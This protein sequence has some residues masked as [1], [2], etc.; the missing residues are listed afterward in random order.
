MGKFLS[1]VDSE[2]SETPMLDILKGKKKKK[3][4]KVKK[5]E[6]SE[7]TTYENLQPEAAELLLKKKKRKHEENWEITN[8]SMDSQDDDEAENQIMERAV[9]EKTKKEKKPR[10]ENEVQEENAGFIKPE[11]CKEKMKQSEVSLPQTP[12]TTHVTT[13]KKRPLDKESTSKKKKRR[14]LDL[15][16]EEMNIGPDEDAGK[17]EI[18]ESPSWM[19]D[20]E[21]QLLNNMKAQLPRK[22]KMSYRTR[23]KDFNWENAAFGNFTAGDCKSHFKKILTGI[24]SVKTLTI[25]LDEVTENLPKLNFNKR[26]IL[27]P[28][29]RFMRET[30]DSHK[31]QFTNGDCSFVNLS[32]A[33][34]NLPE[35]EKDLYRKPYKK[36]LAEERARLLSKSSRRIKMGEQ[37]PV[38]LPRSPLQIWIAEE[39]KQPNKEAVTCKEWKQKFQNLEKEE[40]LKHII[41]SLKEF[42]EYKKS[43]DEYK[44]KNPDFKFPIIHSPIKSDIQLFLEYRGMPMPPPTRPSMILYHELRKAGELDQISGSEKLMVAM[45]RYKNL[46]SSRKL[47]YKSIL[48]KKMEEYRMQMHA[49]EENQDELTLFMRARLLGDKIKKTAPSASTHHKLLK[50]SETFENVIKC[51]M[52]IPKFLDGPCKPPKSPF[53]LFFMRIKHLAQDQY[54]SQSQIKNACLKE[55]KNLSKDEK[56]RYT[57][58]CEELKEKYAEQILQYVENMNKNLRRL[59]LGVHRKTLFTFFQRDIFEEVYPNKK[60]PVYLLHPRKRKRSEDNFSGEL[61]DD[62]FTADSLSGKNNN[63]NVEFKKKKNENKSD[64]LQSKDKLSSDGYVKSKAVKGTS[65]SD[66]AKSEKGKETSAPTFSLFENKVNYLGTK[67]ILDSFSSD[68]DQRIQENIKT[69][70]EE[71]TKTDSDSE[72]DIEPSQSP[73][74]GSAEASLTT[75]NKLESDDSSSSDGYSDT[76]VMPAWK[77]TKSIRKKV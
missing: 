51:E 11:E 74:K 12:V 30:L 24:K 7:Y 60:Y 43:A 50:P 41:T 3:K 4:K 76:D 44:E 23:L 75:P 18:L 62:D 61:S 54:E 26:K 17:D 72:C 48:H 47:N 55:W 45:E 73:Y 20:D 5:F 35:E 1:Q 34:K 58:R 65:H 6:E 56:Q 66:I 46:P 16:N 71:S 25:V 10:L 70:E 59:Y 29:H 64:S 67:E 63:K 52:S 69:F 53:M 28:I 21:L 39:K 77:T 57:E 2:A 27:L 49:W 37:G 13:P 42:Y 22:D 68:D 8:L 15:S 9:K 36:E 14:S 31:K 40:K 38:D 33:W 32:K 19:K